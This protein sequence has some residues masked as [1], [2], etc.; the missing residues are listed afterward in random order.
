MSTFLSGLILLFVYLS[1]MV[2]LVQ[3]HGDTSIANFT[4]GGGVMLVALYTFLTTALFF[5]RHILVTI[6]TLLWAARLIAYVYARYDGRDPRFATWKWQGAKALVINMCWIFG[7]FIM[8]AVMSYPIVLVNTSTVQ[9]LGG[10]DYLG[11]IIW[12][13]GFC[14]ES[15]SDYQLFIFR[16]NPAN[17]G[18]VMR[19]GL[20][21]YSRHPNYF[22]EVLMW[23]GIYCIALCVPYGWTAI[24]APVTIT[25]LLVCVTGVPW[26]EKTFENNVEYQEY[27][28]KTS[29]FVPWLPKKS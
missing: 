16:R 15:L 13:L 23:W 27:K 8:I 7:Q 18:R 14:C 17:A 3:W 5:P 9:G 10:L 29:M 19:Y 21:K 20:W 12:I 1:C 28:R 11:M 2:A 6:M 22:G 25:Y 26:I 4:W 24:I